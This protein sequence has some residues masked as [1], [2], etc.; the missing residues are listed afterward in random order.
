[1]KSLAI[2][3]SN[4]SAYFN[5]GNAF[6]AIGLT[7]EAVSAFETTLSVDPIHEGSKVMLDRI[8]GWQ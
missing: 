5:L 8:K 4:A 1:E 6:L 7:D 3:A 2:D